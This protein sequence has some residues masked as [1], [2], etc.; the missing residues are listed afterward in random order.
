MWALT[1]DR[2]GGGDRTK[3]LVSSGEKNGNIALSWC[4]ANLLDARVKPPDNVFA[5]SPLSCDQLQDMWKTL[6]SRYFGGGLPPIRIEWSTRL[7]ASSGLFVSQVGPKNRW[8]TQAFRHGEARVIRLSAPLL[9]EQSQEEI[10]RTL[11]HEMIHQWQYDVRKRRPS[12]GEDFRHMMARMNADGLRVQVRHD[13]EEGLEKLNRYAWQCEK[14]GFA[15]YRHR[16]TIFPARHVCSRC[17]GALMEVPVQRGKESFP[18]QESGQKA[19]TPP[20]V[21]MTSVQLCFDFGV[22]DSQD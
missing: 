14:C 11:A 2:G 8:V 1:C 17:H 16:R 4:I 5:D 6:D 10:Q 21:E 9:K 3:V 12:H 15:Y 22:H 19:S 20:D 18:V 13:L 7:T